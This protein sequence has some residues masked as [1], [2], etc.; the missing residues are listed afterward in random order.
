LAASVGTTLGQQ[1]STSPAKPIPAPTPI[2]LAKVSLEM[3][4][5]LATLQEID[6]NV[7]KDQSSADRIARPFS[8]SANEIET[9]I[10]ADTRLL[11]TSPSLDVLF[12]LK[13]AWQS[14][15]IR[16]SALARAS[17]QHATS[18]EE[19]LGCLVP[20]EFPGARLHVASSN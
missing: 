2:P 1:A 13:L 4:D 5:T 12:P 19:E 14:F 20:R 10:V 9:R 18:L 16:L 15:D 7:S 3:Q 6:A 17:R 11:T 8:N